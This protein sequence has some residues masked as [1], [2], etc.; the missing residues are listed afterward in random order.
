MKKDE[1]KPDEYEIKA[2][3]YNDVFRQ[4]VE[5]LRKEYDIPSNGFDT[6]GQSYRWK[7]KLS[8]KQFKDYKESIERLMFNYSLGYGWRDGLMMYVELGN[9]MQL[10]VRHNWGLRFS[11]KGEASSPEELRDIRIDV[12]PNVTLK[13]L[14][15]AHK[16]I[17]R[18][19][20]KAGM[21]FK[22][23][24]IKN[25]DRDHAVY[26]KFKQGWK[27]TQITEWLNQ[28]EEEAFNDDNTKKIVSRARK[29]FGERHPWST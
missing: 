28:N 16:A 2:L 10:R 21:K 3:L 4:D 8:E 18:L 1:L 15:E 7:D 5:S 12:D 23:Q 17:R 29:R 14:E 13:D 24:Q 22:K 19:V 25:L 20:G 6:S 27:V 11:Y 26:E 9:E